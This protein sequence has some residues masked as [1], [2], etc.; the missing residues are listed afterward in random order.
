MHL[1]LGNALNYAIGDEQK[2]EDEV[3]AFKK[4]F[5]VIN[6]H[7][8]CLFNLSKALIQTMKIKYFS[9]KFSMI[10]I[11]LKKNKTV[12]SSLLYLFALQV[13]LILI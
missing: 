8:H 13:L 12:V 9:V 2:I 7:V 5:L 3:N 11:F 4:S 6:P 1:Q 10:S